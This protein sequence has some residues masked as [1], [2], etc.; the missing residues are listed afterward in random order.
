MKCTDRFLFV[1]CGREMGVMSFCSVPYRVA[2]ALMAVVMVLGVGSVGAA[3][4]D[5]PV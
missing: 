2:V 3:R 1:L 4:A 5:D